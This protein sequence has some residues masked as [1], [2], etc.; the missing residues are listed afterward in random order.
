MLPLSKAMLSRFSSLKQKKYRDQQNLYSVSGFNAVKMAVIAKNLNIEALLVRQDQIEPARQI[1]NL[2]KKN[3][4]IPVYKLSR[5]EFSQLSDEQSPQGIAIIVKKPDTQI[6]PDKITENSIIYLDNIN[7]PG[8]L[9]T[10]IR[11]AAWFDIR[12]IMLSPN[13]ADP[14]QP[15]TTRASAGMICYVKI[16]E[17]V[18]I[19]DLNLLKNNFKYKLIGATPSLF[20]DSEGI[21]EAKHPSA[22]ERRVL[23]QTVPQGKVGVLPYFLPIYPVSGNTYGQ[24]CRLRVNQPGQFLFGCGIEAEPGQVDG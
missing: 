12:T 4:T 5:K 18:G 6:Q 22:A 19:P 2:I 24:E 23:P 8:N 10:I 3:N 13:S 21:G 16:Y 20:H 14:F 1:Q 11:T 9:G 15:K 7:D 17:N